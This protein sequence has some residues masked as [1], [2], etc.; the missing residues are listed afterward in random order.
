MMPV[1]LATAALTGMPAL[2]VHTA[3]REAL[4]AARK[5]ARAFHPA[6]K[7]TIGFLD[8][9]RRSRASVDC[10][11][12]FTFPK[13]NNGQCTRTWRVRYAST[14]SRKLV[15]RPLGDPKC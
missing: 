8:C 11:V 12:T 10:R 4:A 15:T 9:K 6:P 3:R 1:L 7:V 2:P 14:S 5:A 13:P